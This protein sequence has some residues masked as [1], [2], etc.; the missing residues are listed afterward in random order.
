MRWWETE[1][2]F[3]FSAS[4]PISLRKM[5]WEKC[6]DQRMCP[7]IFE[8]KSNICCSLEVEE[9]AVS[10]GRSFWQCYNYSQHLAHSHYIHMTNLSVLGFKNVKALGSLTRFNVTNSSKRFVNFN[11]SDGNILLVNKLSRNV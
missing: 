4:L 8:Q 1:E 11:Y 3:S 9:A 7:C 5:P 2:M 6:K 10:A